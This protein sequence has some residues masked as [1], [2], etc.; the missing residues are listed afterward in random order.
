MPIKQSAYFK[1]NAR[2]PVPHPDRKGIVMEYLF[3]HV[4][5]E[6]VATTDI[7]E[8]FP[9]FP[10]GK[11]V[12]FDFATENVGPINLTLG[13]MSGTPGELNSARTSGAELINAGA[14]ATPAATSLT[15]ISAIPAIGET[16]VSL[17]LKVSNDI[18]AAA[19]NKLHIRI[20]VVS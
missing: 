10:Y 5:T 16:P 4:F 1:G 7:L 15:A 9:I 17:G 8:L 18:S 12:G 13:L 11:I 3:T 19:N 6:A 20:R 2:T 14:A